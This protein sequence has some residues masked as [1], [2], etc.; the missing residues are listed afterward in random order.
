MF[1]KR[2]KYATITLREKGASPVEVRTT[3]WMGKPFCR[4]KGTMIAKGSKIANGALGL[5]VLLAAVFV[6]LQALLGK[7]S[8]RNMAVID[9]LTA[10]LS[11]GTVVVIGFLL[12]ALALVFLSARATQAVSL[13]LFAGFVISCGLWFFIDFD[14]MGLLVPNQMVVDSI[15]DLS[16]GFI[17]LFT[18]GYLLRLPIN[19]RYK[20]WLLVNQFVLLGAQFFYLVLLMF[21]LP[22]RSSEGEFL[23]A[24]LL[25]G[26]SML[27][28]LY[29]VSHEAWVAKNKHA[30]AVFW[31]VALV[32]LGIT[33]DTLDYYLR[34]AEHG[35]FFHI[36]FL[37]AL[38]ATL[39]WMARF[40]LDNVKQAQ[41][42]AQLENELLQSRIAVMMSQI[43]PHFIFNTLNA[44]S[45]LCLTDPIKA[46]ETVVTF[47][48]YL[49]ENI[50]A[51]EEP[52]PIPFAQELHHVQNYVK[53]EQ[54]RF[55]NKLAV[56]YDIEFSDFSIP[57]LT[58]QPVVENAIRHGIGKKQGSGL[59]RIQTSRQGEYAVVVV[60]DDGVGFDQQGEYGRKDSIGMK[61]VQTR[62]DC[63]VKATMTVTSRPGEGTKTVIQIPLEGRA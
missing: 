60:E 14:F 12:L 3:V 23:L 25:L 46:D 48:E 8:G 20:K 57:T 50:N 26:F 4:G 11:A 63:L 41:R 47:S 34:V 31:L 22:L 40:V 10:F 24:L 56:A 2:V 44:I 9:D 45:A 53:I 62:L 39:F 49:R 59:V 6:A 5:C 43:K 29:C 30:R 27:N 37:V 32:F 52:A 15:D 28:G 7:G 35:Y 54:T 1:S 21:R 17:P 16:L 38:L 42:A 51:L 55:G 13:L 18:I 19:P 58:L 61:N 33:T 36:A